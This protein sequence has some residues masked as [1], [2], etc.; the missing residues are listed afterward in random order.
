MFV[1][2][3]DS[4]SKVTK[5]FSPTILSLLLLIH[6][7][8]YYSYLHSDQIHCVQ[9]INNFPQHKQGKTCQLHLILTRLLLR[10]RS[11]ENAATTLSP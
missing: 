4:L 2:R 3:T 5:T 10:S 8:Y 11:K 1:N 7:Y 6:C 9:G